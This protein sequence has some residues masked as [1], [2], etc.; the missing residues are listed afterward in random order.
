MSETNNN[1]LLA[2][3]SCGCPQGNDIRG[4]LDILGQAQRRGIPQ[5]E[6]CEEAWRLI[7][8]TNPMPAVCGRICPHPC[9]EECNRVVKDYAINFH[10]IERFIGDWGIAHS[11]KHQKLADVCHTEKIA[12]IG[13]GP[14][15]LS[16][17]YHLAKLGYKCTI[18]EASPRT[19]GMLRYG[20][21]SYRLPRHILDREIDN[22][23]ELGIDLRLNVSIGKDIHLKQLQ[24]EYDR[25]FLGIGAQSSMALNV[26]GEDMEGVFSGL[27]FLRMVNSGKEVNIGE[28]VVVIGG[29]NTAVD[30][31]RDAVRLGADATII[32]RRT[33]EEMPA[34]E[35]EIESAEEEGIK[36]VFL[37]AP[38]EIQPDNGKK[39]LVCQRMELGEPDSSGRKRPVPIPNDTFTISIDSLIIAVSQQ[40]D[41][42]GIEDLQPRWS[43][44]SREEKEDRGYPIRNGVYSGG[45]VT[46]VGIATEALAQGRKAAQ[47]IHAELRGL[48][49][50]QFEEDLDIIR[51]DRLHL[52]VLPETQR[53]KMPRLSVSE[54]KKDPWGEVKSTFSAEEIIAESRR[55]VTCGESFIKH[56]KTHPIHILRRIIQIGVGTL[57]FNSFWGVINSKMVYGGPLRN[58]CVPGLNC[59]SCPTALM[60]CPIGMMQHF[61]ATH[62]FPWYL[63]GFL[64]IIGL[65]SGRFTCG[66]LCPWGLI[67]DVLYKIKKM[68]VRIP[69]LLI[70]FKY[71]V[72]VVVVIILPYLTYEHWF[73]K[74]C[75]CGALIAGIPW[76]LWN[77]VDPVFDMTVIDPADVGLMFTIKLWIL[78][79]FLVLFLFIKRPFCR[80]ICPLGAIYALFNRISLVSLE[81][82]DSCTN[83]GQC[84]AVCPTDLDPQNEVNS[85][86]CIK[87]LECVQC[88][89][90]R[91]KWNWPWLK[92]KKKAWT[93][94][95]PKVEPAPAMTCQ[96]IDPAAE[97]TN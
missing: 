62:R 91:Y 43:L 74:L 25:V 6:A 88:E 82:K 10:S 36:L 16:C 38:I 26:A 27:E 13:S 54:R 87:C 50:P 14:A 56:P 39:K 11:L 64:G 20:I 1:T 93:V 19:G 2:P 55:C 69:K 94:V 4:V 48:E 47:T 65:L 70:Y 7:T 15:G 24:E 53:P 66:W 21:P 60:G 33:R 76:V 86:G 77:P 95:A 85:E 41:W 35:E 8:E 78:G 46:N 42:S 5:E 68:T 67:Q 80:T 73:S 40:P 71:A 28:R 63:I 59:H 32:Y 49:K 12:I 92:K 45:D 31:A 90:I 29:G 83:C 52:D 79:I 22:I 23:L 61:A 58:I 9:E 72:L 3:C 17:A 18:F 96:K 89:H 57:L 30:A 84:K 51:A 97:I 34:I 37:A 75:P 81:V 44:F